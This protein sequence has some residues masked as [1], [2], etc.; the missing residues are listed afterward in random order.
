MDKVI[1][2]TSLDGK[3]NEVTNYV[4]TVMFGNRAGSM[5]LLFADLFGSVV[6]L[7]SIEFVSE[8]VTCKNGDLIGW[9]PFFL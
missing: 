6:K 4:P 5:E 3:G 7:R 1:I 8:R 9:G 2:R